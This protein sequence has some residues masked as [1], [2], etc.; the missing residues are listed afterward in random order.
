MFNRTIRVHGQGFGETPASIT[1]TY[2]GN[3][4]F[5]GQIPTV[6]QPI[7]DPI[8]DV[9]VLFSFEVPLQ[10]KGEFPQTVTV[11]AGIVAFGPISA[12]YNVG[13]NGEP[14]GP[15]VYSSVNSYAW[16]AD[17]EYA[18]DP[19]ANPTIDGVAVEDPGS[20]PGAGSTAWYNIYQGSTLA[21]DLVI[22]PGYTPS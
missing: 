19:R 10:T 9:P 16:T 1:A 2:N 15:N 20:G 4:V 22:V 8:P 21:Y 14:P 7:D 11:D 17:P 5:S 3:V 12:N 13:A 18:I 6:N